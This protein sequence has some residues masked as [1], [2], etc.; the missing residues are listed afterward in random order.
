MKAS[1]VNHIACEALKNSND[2]Y[3]VLIGEIKQ[4]AEKGLFKIEK[5]NISEKTLHALRNDGYSI[6][7]YATD[8]GNINSVINW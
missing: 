1:A 3:D 7:S 4:C 2:E 8:I 6:D 5:C